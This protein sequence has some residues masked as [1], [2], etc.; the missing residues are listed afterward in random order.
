MKLILSR[1]SPNGRYNCWVVWNGL[2]TRHCMCKT[3]VI[4]RMLAFWTGNF[5]SNSVS[6]TLLEIEC[7]LSI[8]QQMGSSEWIRDHNAVYCDLIRNWQLEIAV[9]YQSGFVL[10]QPIPFFDHLA[11]HWN[12]I[13]QSLDSLICAVCIS[14]QVRLET[15]MSQQ[16]MKEKHQLCN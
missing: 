16:I 9:G 5:L 14:M 11:S 1:K 2:Q 3:L 8:I 4:S 7:F 6:G 12:H 13:I 10:A 15:K